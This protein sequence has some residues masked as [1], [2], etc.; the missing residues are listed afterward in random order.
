MVH[1]P[2]RGRNDRFFFFEDTDLKND[3]YCYLFQLSGPWKLL[4]PLARKKKL[5]WKIH[6][7]MELETV[8]RGTQTEER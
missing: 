1:T 4:K 8:P 7:E 5:T 3:V 6:R 2:Y